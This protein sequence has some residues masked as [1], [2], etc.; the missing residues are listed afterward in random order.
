MRGG[1]IRAHELTRLSIARVGKITRCDFV[2]PARASRRL[3]QRD[4]FSLAQRK[5]R[6]KARL[7]C[8]AFRTSTVWMHAGR[9]GAKPIAE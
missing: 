7:K 2:I 4:T 1:L 5:R 6:P 8:V 3:A 9:S